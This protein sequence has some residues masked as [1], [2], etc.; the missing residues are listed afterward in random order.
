M[1][2][3]HRTR[4]QVCLMRGGGVRL[5]AV[6]A[7]LWT[8]RLV[9]KLCHCQLCMLWVC[10]PRQSSDTVHTHSGST[11]SQ[12]RP[13]LA[14]CS[15]SRFPFSFCDSQPCSSGDD[16]IATMHNHVQI[17]RCMP[18][19]HTEMS[20][21][22]SAPIFCTRRGQPAAAELCRACMSSV[23]SIVPCLAGCGGFTYVLVVASVC[24]NARFTSSTM[25]CRHLF[26]FVFVEAPLIVWRT[27]ANRGRPAK[28]LS[29][30]LRAINRLRTF[31]F[32]WASRRG[33]RGPAW[34]QAE[35][36][37]ARPTKRHLLRKCLK[38]RSS[39]LELET[40]KNVAQHTRSS[41]PPLQ[42]QRRLW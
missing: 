9:A 39:S 16:E 27:G 26:V 35:P 18:E 20:K 4:C 21:P 22:M 33:R 31:V 30:I 34:K 10:L 23:A 42:R 19:K 37:R 41:P 5:G 28:L 17:S 7:R 1:L 25:N 8:R 40:T 32:F 15:N 12:P 3:S 11:L 14:M 24:K 29:L 38:S 2:P 13:N 6:W 36:V